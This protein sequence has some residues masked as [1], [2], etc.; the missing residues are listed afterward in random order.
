[1]TKIEQSRRSIEA[2]SKRH[3]D[4]INQKRRNTLTTAASNTMPD[5]PSAKTASGSHRF[6]GVTPLTVRTPALNS[7]VNFYSG[8]LK[9]IKPTQNN[10]EL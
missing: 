8:L 7:M 2:L 3:F 1:M 10:K 5:R 9:D 4:F 6:R